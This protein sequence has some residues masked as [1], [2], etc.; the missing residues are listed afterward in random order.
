MAEGIVVRPVTADRWDDLVDL[1]ERRGP[2]GGTPMTAGCWCMWWRQRTG[3]PEQNKTN[4]HH[5]VTSGAPP[6]LLAYRSGHPV[7][8]VSISPREG[9]GQLMRS[10]RY[11]P[12]DDQPDVYAL[13]CFYVQTAA[14][15][16]GVA[17][18]LLDAALDHARSCG[19]RAVEAYPNVRTDFMGSRKEF[20][21]RGF[22]PVRSAGTRIVMRV[23]F[24]EHT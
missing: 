8:W 23:S 2:R 4:M 18:T 16:Q 20:E 24:D 19:A 15:R 11:R 10:P 12:A 14:K 9:L 5:L 3:G 22:Q 17:G 21:R 7:G 13:V 6:G 1:F